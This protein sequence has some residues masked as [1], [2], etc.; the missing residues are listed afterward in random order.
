MS[1][2]LSREVLGAIATAHLPRRSFPRSAVTHAVAECEAGP[3]G[4]DRRAMM[5][6]CFVAQCPF[7]VR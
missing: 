7:M 2:D 6:D 1:F 5:P 3:D 4:F